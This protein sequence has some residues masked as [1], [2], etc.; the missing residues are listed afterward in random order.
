MMPLSRIERSAATAPGAASSSSSSARMRSPDSSG[1]PA[2][3]AAAAARPSASGASA[4]PYS[5]AEAEEAQDAQ[6]VLADALA[7]VADE[8]HALGLEVAVA[9]ERIVHR[10]V[11]IAIERVHGEVAPHGVLA[12]V[13]GERH[14]RVAAERLDVAAQRRHFERHLARQRRSPCR[15][16]CRSAPRAGRRAAASRIT[17]CG[18]RR[19][20]D[21]DVLD[22][23]AHQRIAHR[24]TDG[25]R[26]GPFGGE[27]RRTRR[28]FAGRVS[29][30]A[31]ARLGSPPCV[32]RA[33][34]RASRG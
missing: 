7:R 34:H 17:S 30:S 23:C 28:A 11:G 32:L 10:A 16:R 1:S 24:A 29:H 9:A 3:S 5:R 25:A 4:S 22:R 21:V 31:S 2:F 18:Q 33:R 14:L 6:V 12:P 20:R 19:R 13:G 8:A 15:A 26:F 27:R